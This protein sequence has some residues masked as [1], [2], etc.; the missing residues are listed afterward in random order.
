[1]PTHPRPIGLLLERGLQGREIHSASLFAMLNDLR[2]WRVARAD[3]SQYAAQLREGA[4]PVGSVEFVRAA[5]QACALR[6]PPNLTYPDALKDFLRRDVCLQR[7]GRIL[8]TRFV[9]PVQTKRFT[10]FVF[11]PMASPEH[12]QDAFVREQHECFLSLSAD[13]LVWSGEPV[14]WL[15]EV[16]YYVLAGQVLGEGRY[17]DGADDAPLP[18]REEVEA[19]VRAWSARDGAPQAYALDVGVLRSGETALIECNDAWALG[20]YRGSLE[21]EAYLEMLWRRWQQI[22]TPR[23]P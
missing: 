7:A 15:S 3:V 2:V 14:Q 22:C 16:R 19:M 23:T 18:S 8:Q 9:K 5:M 10:G 17:D 11:D 4:L 6:E 1:M 12:Q 21:R 13:D 20:Y